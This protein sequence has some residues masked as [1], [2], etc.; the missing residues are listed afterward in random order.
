MNTQ[1]NFKTLVEDED[2]VIIKKVKEPLHIEID[3]DRLNIDDVLLLMKIRGEGK[4]EGETL[5]T[6][7]PIVD[8]CLVNTSVSELPMRVLRKLFA[9]IVS[10]LETANE[11][12][13]N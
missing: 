8:R 7:L 4:E 10:S 1:E 13:K 3:T 9:T 2:L 11:D 6:F 12:A 5:Q